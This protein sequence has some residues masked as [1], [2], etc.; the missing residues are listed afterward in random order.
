[1][2]VVKKEMLNGIML[3]GIGKEIKSKTDIV[4]EIYGRATFGILCRFLVVP[5]QGGYGSVGKG[6]KEGNKNYQRAGVSLEERLP[7][8]GVVV[9]KGACSLKGV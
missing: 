3:S 7:P 9:V 2:A 5:P 8:W 6:G 4:S 1:M